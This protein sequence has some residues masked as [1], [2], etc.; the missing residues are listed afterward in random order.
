MKLPAPKEKRK[1]TGEKFITEI[2]FPHKLF[3]AYLAAQYL[4]SLHETNP[5]EFRR[6]LKDEILGRC[7][8]FTYLL[9]FIA[10]NG[11]ASERELMD[12]LCKQIL[13]QKQMSFL[14]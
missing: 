8:E 6:L 7:V 2:H 11:G 12:V 14:Y 3:Q 4:A 13:L 10:G 5:A 1:V 9:Y